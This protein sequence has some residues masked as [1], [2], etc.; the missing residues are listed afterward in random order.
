MAM[1]RYSAIARGRAGD[2]SN[3]RRD[4]IPDTFEIDANCPRPVSRFL[5]PL[6]TFSRVEIRPA[7]HLLD[8]RVWGEISDL[9][10]AHCADISR[11][12]RQY[13]RLNRRMR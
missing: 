8:C 9:P 7:D 5:T 4:V 12:Q 10:I 2:T 6:T 1:R 3:R 13:F 11:Y